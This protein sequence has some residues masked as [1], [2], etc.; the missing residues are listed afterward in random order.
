[1]KRYP[2]IIL[3]GL[4][5]LA[6][7][8]AVGTFWTK[9]RE[10]SRAISTIPSVVLL[11]NERESAIEIVFLHMIE[12]HEAHPTYFLSFGPDNDPTDSFMAR[13]K[14]SSVVT[15][16]LSEAVRNDTQVIDRE[17]GKVGVQLKFGFYIP[18]SKSEAVVSTGW[19]YW[20][21]V[22]R[23]PEGE[24]KSYEYRLQK[25]DGSWRIKTRKFE[26][27]MF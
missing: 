19:E 4:V 6:L 14:G 13:F 22:G 23:K 3:I 16:K 2:A 21:R 20:K 12:S 10:A 15:R 26:P 7:G 1:M 27:L 17:S 18:I 9:Q 24:I 8:I 5:T 11:P 25:I